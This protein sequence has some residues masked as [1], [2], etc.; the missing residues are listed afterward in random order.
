LSPSIKP[1]KQ[2]FKEHLNLIYHV[3]K[4]FS[5]NS[6]LYKK[7]SDVISCVTWFQG[8]RMIGGLVS[9]P[10]GLMEICSRQ[11][12]INIVTDPITETTKIGLYFDLHY[13][14]CASYDSY[15]MF[16]DWMLHVWSYFIFSDTHYFK[17]LTQIGAFQEWKLD[18]TAASGYTNHWRSL[19]EFLL[20]LQ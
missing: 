6:K 13:C 12:I 15:H 8:Y 5:V 20:I 7:K 16:S 18:I 4:F 14:K 3:N 10:W 17:I 1:P 19:L 9:R 11:E 2:D